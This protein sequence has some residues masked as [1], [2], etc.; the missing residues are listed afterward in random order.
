MLYM[1]ILP[2]LFIDVTLSSYHTQQ[3]TPLSHAIILLHFIFEKQLEKG[4]SEVGKWSPHRHMWRQKQNIYNVI[5]K[6]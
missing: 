1:N 2:M 4:A 5:I 6:K 3:L